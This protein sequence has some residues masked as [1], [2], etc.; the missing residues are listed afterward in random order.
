MLF[1]QLVTVVLA[2]KMFMP[3]TTLGRN[4]LSKLKMVLTKHPIFANNGLMPS[5]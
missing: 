4:T 3:F 5:P 1:L 2:G